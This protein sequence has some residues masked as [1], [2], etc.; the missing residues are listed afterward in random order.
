MRPHKIGDLVC[1]AEEAGGGEVVCER[2]VRCEIMRE[3]LLARSPV[4]EA[5][6]ERRGEGRAGFD[7]FCDEIRAD[8]AEFVEI[9]YE[10]W[11]PL[12]VAAED[13]GDVACERGE[14]MVGGGEG[15][16]TVEIWGEEVGR[17]RWTVIGWA[18]IGGWGFEVGEHTAVDDGAVL[19]WAAVTV[20]EL[21]FAGLWRHF[22]FSG[23]G[24][25]M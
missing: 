3:A 8:V 20:V 15:G 5:C 24:L 21:W 22:S 9:R 14:E 17:G 1:G 7:D 11:G 10:W 4:E 19:G 13:V 12:A 6:G 16:W 25:V 23:F 18:V 2:V